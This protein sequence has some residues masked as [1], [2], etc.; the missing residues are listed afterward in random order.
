M[1]FTHALAVKSFATRQNSDIGYLIPIFVE[2]ENGDKYPA[3]IYFKCES[4]R[5]F[6]VGGYS[7]IEKNFRENQI[8][9]IQIRESTSYEDK[10]TQSQQIFC[11]FIADGDSSYIEKQP[12]KIE[13]KELV[14][15]IDA[16]L[17]SPSNPII[18]TNTSP[19]T[20]YIA[21]L[22]KDGSIYFLF[23]HSAI[24]NDELNSSTLALKVP[25]TPLMQAANQGFNIRQVFKSSL[26][27]LDEYSV[28]SISQLGHKKF[29]K[30]VSIVIKK[31]GLEFLEF[32]SD[33]DLIETG[34]KMIEGTS[35]SLFNKNQIPLYKKNFQNKNRSAPVHYLKFLDRFFL[36]LE[37]IDNYS[38]DTIKQID[39]F[40]KTEH[41][42]RL[43][44]KYID[45]TPQAY[46]KLSSEIKNRL[47][48][49]NENKTT[50]F[51]FQ[52]NDL[53]IKIKEAN[54][55]IAELNRTRELKEKENQESEKANNSS[56]LELAASQLNSD[57]A[58]KKQELEKISALVDE[59][60][61]KLSYLKTIQHIQFEI[62]RLTHDK[63]Q[64]E[65]ATAS[66]RAEFAENDSKLFS[67][68]IEW[69]PYIE[70]LTS[71]LP[72]NASTEKFD[73]INIT[74][75]IINQINTDL[76]SSLKDRDIF[77]EKIQSYF[78]NNG[79]SFTTP[80]IINIL[81]CYQQSFITVLAGLPGVGKTSTVQLLSEACGSN[82]RLIQIPVGRGWTSN[83]D[84][85]GY[86]NPLARKFQSAPNKFYAALK[87]LKKEDS[88]CSNKKQNPMITIL[89]DEANLSPIEHYWSSFMGMTDS[90][91]NRSL[92]LG[93][94]S[95]NLSQNVRF[96]ATINFDATT[97]PLSPR[98]L[99]RAPV[100][101]LEPISYFAE[102][103]TLSNENTI[104]GAYSVE[105]MEEWF[106]KPNRHSSWN[107]SGG[108]IIEAL[109]KIASDPAIKSSLPISISHRK[110]QAIRDYVV[111]ADTLL[112]VEQNQHLAI[113]YAI[114]QFILPSISGTGD[115]YRIRLENMLNF[116]VEE[117]LNISANRLSSIIEKG[118]Q[119]L[120][121]YSFFSW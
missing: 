36:T 89:L 54:A 19:L 75:P 111:R 98:M 82:N 51:R 116:L 79:R 12:K 26:K 52:L 55:R 27:K 45:E 81:I 15:V 38:Q 68:L 7:S 107:E 84:L 53:E 86:Y 23:D 43:I 121:S 31:E 91:K 13:D 85:I 70:S 17:P 77:I 41:G 112:R 29:I 113:D 47:I 57:L 97:E 109:I 4:K 59:A 105:T 67:K 76:A 35:P 62:D 64:L 32:M 95:F 1:K 117:N 92:I 119:D 101:L 120:D 104:A 30:D 96:I 58:D 69:R 74:I 65:R 71:I 108:G 88:A 33:S 16:E 46:E 21:L 40:F 110:K 78:S 94:E 50:Q 20:R 118:K 9:R 44:G 99:D 14:E 106:G 63:E 48:E 34:F 100:I 25:Q 90:D 8:F 37:S 24:E 56:I 18:I 103:E 60:H 2:T 5:I 39:Y 72:T 93:D 61:K 22:S 87:A 114:A 10:K 6:V 80:D 83:R 115:G 73:T 28:S 3:D 49:D 102:Y 66:L 42:K 11:K